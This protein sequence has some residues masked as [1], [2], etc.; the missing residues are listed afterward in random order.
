MPAILAVK[1]KVFCTLSSSWISL[2]LVVCQ[3][4]QQYSTKLR[5]MDL[6]IQGKH[7]AGGSSMKHAEYPGC[8]LTSF[9]GNDCGEGTMTNHNKISNDLGVQFFPVHDS[10]TWLSSPPNSQAAQQQISFCMNNHLPVQ[11]P[12]L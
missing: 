4:G 10:E 2:I 3:S 8:I 12:K 11:G 1:P 6:F 7:D 9:V 5:T